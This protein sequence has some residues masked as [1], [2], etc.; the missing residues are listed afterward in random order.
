MKFQIEVLKTTYERIHRNGN[1]G[2][3][4]DTIINDALRAL[5]R[6][7]ET[8]FIKNL[9]D[10]TPL[11]GTV[12]GKHL[13]NV[14][15][16]WRHIVIEILRGFKYRKDEF[17]KF[18]NNRLKPGYIPG[19]NYTYI[20]EVDISFSTLDARNA[21]E[22]IKNIGKHFNLDIEIAYKDGSNGR[23]VLLTKRN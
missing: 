21:R 22:L 2:E 23:E 1:N 4:V 8:P 12:D 19:K 18:Q 9:K 13:Q 6:S 3:D 14:N 20:K 7:R 16:G 11:Y 5:E 17:K 15:L 10:N